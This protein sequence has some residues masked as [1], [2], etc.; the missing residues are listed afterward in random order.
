MVIIKAALERPS[1]E[2]LFEDSVDEQKVGLPICQDM[3]KEGGLVVS[4]PHGT[5]ALACLP[6]SIKL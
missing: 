4:I 2:N 5:D 1:I 3:P 6:H